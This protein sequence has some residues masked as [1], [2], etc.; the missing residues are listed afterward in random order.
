[1]DRARIRV[2]FDVMK[3]TKSQRR[4]IRTMSFPMFAILMMTVM[5]AVVG[6][7]Q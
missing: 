6:V 5:M 2:C 4:M 7:S 3:M 1:L